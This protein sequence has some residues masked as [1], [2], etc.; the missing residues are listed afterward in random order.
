M[1]DEIRGD[2]EIRDDEVVNKSNTGRAIG[3][4][5][6]LLVAGCVIWFLVG[7]EDIADSVPEEDVISSSAESV[8]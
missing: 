5:A 7:R 4:I 3:L 1:T 6:I 2:D 8:Q